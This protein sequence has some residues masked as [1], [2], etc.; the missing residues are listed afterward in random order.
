MWPAVTLMKKISATM[1]DSL[2]VVLTGAWMKTISVAR[3]EF[4]QVDLSFII[5]G[6]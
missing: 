5:L 2:V 6:G 4:L 1:I 3:R